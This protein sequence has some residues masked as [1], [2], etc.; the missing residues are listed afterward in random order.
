MISLYVTNTKSS[1]HLRGSWWNILNRLFPK[2]PPHRILLFSWP[3]VFRCLPLPKPWPINI[4]GIASLLYNKY[5][6]RRI[7]SWQF[8]TQSISSQWFQIFGLCKGVVARWASAVV[9]GR[10]EAQGRRRRTFLALFSRSHCQCHCGH[11]MP[12]E[13]HIRF[14]D[15]ACRWFPY[16]G[17][18]VVENEA[19]DTKDTKDVKDV[20]DT[21]D[22]NRETRKM[23]GLVLV[24]RK[25][26]RV[27]FGF[28][29]LPDF[30]LTSCVAQEITQLIY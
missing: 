17:E 25:T 4:A 11:S 20:K 22:A 28:C 6:R 29:N 5:M 18:V 9:W 8:R 7:R 21:K 13:C 27:V 23:Q 15:M 2:H 1:G 26:F 16:K 14:G 12:H 30:S 3:F 10:I 24:G 19:K